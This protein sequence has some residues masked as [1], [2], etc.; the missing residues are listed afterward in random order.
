[1]KESPTP[2]PLSRPFPVAAVLC[3]I[4]GQD[5]ARRRRRDHEPA[6]LQ[7]AL[8]RHRDDSVRLVHLA[9]VSPAIFIGA[10]VG[11]LADVGYFL[12]LDLGATSTLYPARS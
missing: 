3:V 4:W 9:P 10:L 2:R 7:P 12:F 11:G 5:H 6:W 8:D 1:M